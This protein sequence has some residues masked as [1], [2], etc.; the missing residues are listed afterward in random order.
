MMN[1]STPLFQKVS[2]YVILSIEAF[3]FDTD[4]HVLDS[5]SQCEL[6]CT[7]SLKPK[8]DIPNIKSF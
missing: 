2:V 4:H 5:W 1:M 7:L 8:R 6:E 3:G